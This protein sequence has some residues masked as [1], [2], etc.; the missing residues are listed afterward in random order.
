[1]KSKHGKTP[2]M[3]SKIM[4]INKDNDDLMNSLINDPGYQSR[5]K[6]SQTGNNKGY[7]Q[8]YDEQSLAY[9]QR[10]YEDLQTITKEKYTEKVFQSR[11]SEKELNPELTLTVLS[12][13]KIIKDFNV[14]NETLK[15]MNK[16]FEQKEQKNMEKIK[17]LSSEVEKLELEE[18]LL[19][20]EPSNNV[21]YDLDKLDQ[22]LLK[23]DNDL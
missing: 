14:E 10:N 5:K 16:R 12:L 1:M 21:K 20:E 17:T 9:S 22:K 8:N 11:D 19:N 18:M 13:K 2:P 3:N 23:M 6:I 4:D 15:R 7:G